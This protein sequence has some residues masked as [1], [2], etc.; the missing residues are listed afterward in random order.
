LM[1]EGFAMKLRTEITVALENRPGALGHLCRC[2]AENG[3]NILAVSVVESTGM[4][5]VRLVVNKPAAA[6]R[7]FTECCPVTVSACDVLEL[8]APN[9]P[10]VL[11]D[12]AAKLSRRKVNID[13]V[14][15]TAS[16]SGKTALILRASDLKKAAKALKGF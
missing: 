9:R 3:I 7:L 1:K 12:I 16:S 5:L 6:A 2:L 14:Y 13:Y 4:G 15:G 11:A 10:G 8:R